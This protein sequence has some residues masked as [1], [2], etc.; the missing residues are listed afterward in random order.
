MPEVSGLV[1]I[2][3]KTPL[4]S[5]GTL[6]DTYNIKGVARVADVVGP[7]PWLYAQVQKKDWYKPEILEETHYFRGIPIPLTGDFSIDWVPDRVGIYEVTIVATPA[8]LSLPLIGVP[9]IT[10]L[11]SMMKVSIGE[12]GKDVSEFKIIAYG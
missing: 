4:P 8:P 2:E 9:P 5:E 1:E 6:G 7:P 11:S 10:G 12:I 3:I